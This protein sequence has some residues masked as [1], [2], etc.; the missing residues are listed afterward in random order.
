MDDT[1]VV[2]GVTPVAFTDLGYFFA[3]CVAAVI[4][5]FGHRL[6]HDDEVDEARL[7]D[8]SD[9]AALGLFS[10]TGTTKALTHGFNI[11]AA[12][13]LGCASAVGGG[14]LAQL[15]ALEQPTL[16]R[17]NRD[18]YAL[19]ALA[20]ATLAALLY[21]TE[22]LNAATAIGTSLFAF[23]LRLLALRYN[24][25]TPRSHF[26]RNPFAGMRQQPSASSIDDD[27][28]R[29]HSR[30]GDTSTQPLSA[31]ETVRL[32]HI[33]AEAPARPGT[34]SCPWQ[35]PRAPPRTHGSSSVGPRN[36]TRR[37]GTSPHRVSRPCG[38][39]SRTVMTHPWTSAATRGRQW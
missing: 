26:W 6:R 11:P 31:T 8:V 39:R 4:V 27:T 3:P 7:F 18:L 15:L 35:R 36:K 24:W 33:D 1:F 29:L 22:V 2:L 25:R 17:W 20:G 28:V 9:A 10:V 19:P 14:V 21:K 30:K 32:P 34:V 16:L 23:G 12:V 13:T 37:N 5:Y 38:G